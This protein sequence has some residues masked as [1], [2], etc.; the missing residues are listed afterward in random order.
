MADYLRVK[1]GTGT[2]FMWNDKKEEKPPVT[3]PE[4]KP[5]FDVEDF[6]SKMNAHLK[7]QIDP[8]SAAVNDTKTRLEAI[9]QSGKKREEA[10][11]TER[12]SVLDD[13]ER[14]FNEHLAPVASQTVALQARMVE[15]DIM[16]EMRQDGWEDLI[17]DFR[18]YVSKVDIL[19]KANPQYE[20]QCRNVRDMIIGKAAQKNGL[21]R[22]GNSFIL[23][24]ANATPSDPAMQRS[25]QE[26][27][28]FLN[29]EVTTTKGKHVTRKEFLERMGY[30][31]SDPSVVKS[32][33]D[34]WSKV[35]V[36]N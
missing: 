15:R 13:E 4:N 9:E 17:P 24:D 3:P 34:N 1:G 16:D 7:A 20:M 29:Y 32:I 19:S 23:E 2:L 35:Q 11:P 5:A 31:L 10:K 33:K 28:E 12:T 6:F 8:L 26:D 27:R 21:K 18:D 22:R 14:A 25:S 30:D 36:I